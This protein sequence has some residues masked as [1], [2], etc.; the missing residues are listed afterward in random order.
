VPHCDSD[1]AQANSDRE[2][3]RADVV[4]MH[5]IGRK[6]PAERRLCWSSDPGTPLTLLSLLA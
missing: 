1:G 4:A 3:A 2:R 6:G 5:R